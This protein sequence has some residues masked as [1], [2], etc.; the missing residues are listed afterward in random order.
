MKAVSSIRLTVDNNLNHS[1]LA[2]RRKAVALPGKALDRNIGLFKTRVSNLQAYSTKLCSYLFKVLSMTIILVNAVSISSENMS[3]I[4][5][6]LHHCIIQITDQGS[7]IG[8][9][10]RTHGWNDTKCIDGASKPV[11][12]RRQHKTVGR[13]AESL[14]PGKAGFSY[15]SLSHSF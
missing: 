8:L 9:R 5:P 4:M 1:A 10:R 2:R 13:I 14:Y 3:S 15:C 7:C 12:R 6:N 11:W